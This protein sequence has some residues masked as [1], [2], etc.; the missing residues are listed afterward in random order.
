V[1]IVIE[2]IEFRPFS[3]GQ[4]AEQIFEDWTNPPL[5]QGYSNNIV[6]GI[7]AN[8]MVFPNAVANLLII[9]GFL[10]TILARKVRLHRA[11]NISPV[12]ALAVSLSLCLYGWALHDTSR[13]LWRAEQILDSHERYATEPS[14]VR[15][16][17]NPIRCARFPADCKADLLPFY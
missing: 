2:S 10:L 8:G 12:H 9:I 3:A 4:V 16:R 13:W 5:W 11:K 6:R 14:G 17:N 7:H 15:Y 1:D